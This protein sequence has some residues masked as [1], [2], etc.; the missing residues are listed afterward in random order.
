M[1]INDNSMNEAL[2]KKIIEEAINDPET[3]CRKYL[4]LAARDRRS[5]KRIQELE[6]SLKKAKREISTL[7]HGASKRVALEQEK[8]NRISELEALLEE[9]TSK[10]NFLIKEVRMLR[11]SKALK[12]GQSLVRPY[13]ITKTAAK[14]AK[15]SF[16]VIVDGITNPSEIALE[17]SPQRTV[18]D[19]DGQTTLAVSESPSNKESSADEITADSNRDNR[20]SEIGVSEELKNCEAVSDIP[21]GKR[22]RTRLREDFQSDRTALNLARVVNRE[23]FQNGLIDEPAGLILENIDL[24]ENMEDRDR[25]NA[26]RV[27]GAYRLKD[28]SGWIPPRT[29]SPAYTVDENRVLYCVHSTPVYNSN[30]YS[31]RTEGVATGLRQS[32]ANV[33][34]LARMGYPWDNSVD[35]SKPSKERTVVSIDSVDY[36]HVPGANINREP[37]DRY[38]LKTADMIVREART[39]R[40]AVIQAASNHIVAL[41]ALIAARRLGLPFVYEVRGLW[42]ITAASTIEN[43]NKTQRYL[44]ERSLE[45]LVASSADHVLAITRQVKEELIKRGVANERITVAPNAVDTRAFMPIVPDSLF[46]DKYKIPK[47]VPVIG[48]AGSLVSYEGLD[49]LIIASKIL[50]ERG[51]DHKVVIAGSGKSE[52]ALKELRNELKLSTVMFIGRVNSSDVPRLLSCF[53][54]VAC[55]RKSL[56]ITEL[57]SPLKPLE[58]FGTATATVLSS[59][60]P[61]LDLAAGGKRAALC[62]PDNPESLADTLQTLLSDPDRRRDLGRA[63]RLWTVDQRSWRKI[64]G[65]MI[66][67]HRQASDYLRGS[68]SGLVSDYSSITIGLIAD[69]FTTTTL[70][71]SL[72]VV[73]VDRSCWREQLS[74]NRIDILFVESAWKGNSGQWF[75]GVGYYGVD[76]SR[77]L[78]ELVEYCKSVD[79]PTIFW[80]KEDPVHFNRFIKTAAIFDHVAT[81]D[82]RMLDEYQRVLAETG[83]TVQSACFFAEPGIHNPL[84]SSLDFDDTIA[85][86]G[87][88]YGDRYKE[89]SDQ[90]YRMITALEKFGITIYDRQYGETE[91]KYKYPE[92]FLKYVAGGLPYTEV[93]DSYK[94]HFASI[95]VN[96][97]ADSPTMFSRRVV[98]IAACGGLVISGSGLGITSSFGDS[99]CVSNS[100]EDWLKTVSRWKKSELVRRRDSWVQFRAVYRSYLT[101]HAMSILLRTAGLPVACPSF[102]PTILEIGAVSGELLQ[103]IKSQTVLP[104]YLAVPSQEVSAARSY[105]DTSSVEVIEASPVGYSNNLGM[106]H[107]YGKLDVPPGSV[108][109]LED[110]LYATYFGNW[111]VITV[112]YDRHENTRLPLFQLDACD[113]KADVVLVKKIPAAAGRKQY[114][115]KKVTVNET[116]DYKP[117]SNS[118]SP[119]LQIRPQDAKK[120]IVVAG[121]DLKFAKHL[122]ERLQDSGHCVLIDKW[123]SHSKHDE[124]HS[125]QMLEKADTVF[126]EWG[127]GNMV[128]YSEHLKP[129]QRMTVRIHLQE[130]NLPYLKK[131]NKDKISRFFCVGELV[132]RS[133]IASHG[134]PVDRVAVIPNIIDIASLDRPKLP[135]ADK[136]IGF[137]GIVPQR[138]RIDLAID[139]LEILLSVDTE[140]RLF[141]KGKTALDYPWMK[142]RPEELKYYTEQ[143]YRI[144]R[145][146]EHYPD[147]IVFD[148][149]GSDM[150]EWYSKIGTVISTSDFESFHLTI[151]DGAASGSIPVCLAWDGSDMIYPREWLVSDVSAMADR[152]LSAD[153]SPA[154]VTEIKKQIRERFEFEKILGRLEDEICGWSDSS[155]VSR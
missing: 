22:S 125:L 117:D 15:K 73:V 87:S 46:Q 97:V 5:K 85:H 21:V 48:F 96:S 148:G 7:K 111:D 89:R 132:A 118:P 6:K 86:A 67:G 44:L 81:T 151:A 79:I 74:N 38:I 127:L 47:D 13:Q 54:I 101:M 49:D 128:W 10:N 17:T 90:L 84:M 134:V 152:I 143:Q 99:I 42:E 155:E 77:D 100:E 112:A 9:Y 39:L 93:I 71:H 153:R 116:T 140:Y 24:L 147:A 146:L 41:P 144:N 80:N 53:D 139:V 30:G 113:E 78:F 12:V 115:E 64:A 34:V 20:P 103:A 105:F 91:S 104:D 75:R 98:E 19:V 83:G 31:T 33:T 141:I 65:S 11:D 88:Y 55:P 137:V 32:G 28:P 2:V 52:K 45:A 129:H 123:Q 131:A 76:E 57:V 16:D 29:G 136:N 92:E 69:E 121:H 70:S 27:L 114:T 72:N 110:V 37:L 8:T 61:N 36:V 120:I 23:W 66:E 25:W 56:E 109:F 145:I 40:P 68:C 4:G 59:V 106:P 133:A 138:K 102:P 50:A 119:S 35:K 95:N 14:F 60:Q 154:A 150:P 94:R 3:H 58:A 26:E 126:C 135:N 43:W 63:A 82:S 18:P 107:W 62:E 108:T 51:I 1:A 149:H 124:M 142:N 122:I 130:L